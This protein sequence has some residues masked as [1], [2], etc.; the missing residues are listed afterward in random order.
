MQ[1]YWTLVRR[2]LGSFFVS[3]TG[4]II[5][6]GAV[7]MMGWS[8]VALLQTLQGEATPQPVTQLFYSTWYFWSILLLTCPIITMRLFSYTGGTTTL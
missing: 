7:S 8:F 5:I 3:W 6:A 2:E 4:Y 1:A